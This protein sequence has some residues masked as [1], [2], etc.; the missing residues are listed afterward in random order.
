MIQ[1]CTSPEHTR[2]TNLSKLQCENCYEIIKIVIEKLKLIFLSF[3][4]GLI[5]S[6]CLCKLQEKHSVKKINKYKSDREISFISKA[7]HNKIPNSNMGKISVKI[8]QRKFLHTLY[9]GEFLKTFLSAIFNLQAEHGYEGL[10][11]CI[12]LVSFF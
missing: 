2:N 3:W 6:F 11:Y 12:F 9:C 1:R 5:T 4:V 7:Q 8:Q 10:I